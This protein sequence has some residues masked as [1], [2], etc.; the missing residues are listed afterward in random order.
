[1][2]SAVVVGKTVL[3]HSEHLTLPSLAVDMFLI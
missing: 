3:H 1:M 2:N